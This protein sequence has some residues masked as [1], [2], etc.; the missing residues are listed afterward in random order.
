M[1]IQMMN[2]SMDIVILKSYITPT[3]SAFECACITLIT[4]YFCNL[5]DWLL[6]S[7]SHI[8]TKL[9]IIKTIHRIHMTHHKVH[10]PITKLLRSKPY[11]SGGGELAFGPIM[12]LIYGI[13]CILLPLKFALIVLIE[14]TTFLFVS[15]QLHVQYH[16][17]GSYLER[18]DWFQRRRERHFWHHKHLRENMSLGGI[19]PVFD[20]LFRTYHEVEIADN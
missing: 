13:I 16:L 8:P 5:V 14:S 15:D 4:W 19:D 10:Y 7:M 6:H 2:I 9:P 17:Q 3:F 20:R 1:L 18:F 12:A 11:M